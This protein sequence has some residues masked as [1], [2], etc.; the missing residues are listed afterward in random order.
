MQLK[1]IHSRFLAIT[2]SFQAHGG[3]FGLAAV[4]PPFPLVIMGAVATV[5]GVLAVFFP[6]TTGEELPETMEDALNIG[7]NSNFKFAR[8]SNGK[9]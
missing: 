8:C 6:E 2:H 1:R 7:K 9:H 5:A 4:W 3:C